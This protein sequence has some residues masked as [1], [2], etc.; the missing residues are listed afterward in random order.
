MACEYFCENCKQLRAHVGDGTPVVCGN[1][2]SRQLDRAEL[3]SERLALRRFGSAGQ[4]EDAPPG[5]L[6]LAVTSHANGGRE[7]ENLSTRTLYVERLDLRREPLPPGTI[8]FL[9]PGEQLVIN[10]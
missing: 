1:C 8:A 2:G 5:A 7:V 9:E 4:P 6:K 10:P 3:G